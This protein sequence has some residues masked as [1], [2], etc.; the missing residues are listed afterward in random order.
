M[1]RVQVA[2]VFLLCTV[3]GSALIFFS[4]ARVPDPSSLRWV[5]GTIE[6]ADITWKEDRNHTVTEDSRYEL[7][8]RLDGA[9]K[10]EHEYILPQAALSMEAIRGLLHEEVQLDV[11]DSRKIYG[12]KNASGTVILDYATAVPYYKRYEDSWPMRFWGYFFCVPMVII[13]ISWTYKTLRSRLWPR[14]I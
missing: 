2:F 9:G 8:V 3:G 12:I 5:P 6:E 7:T 1:W 14:S 13:A 10:D 4:Y 11:Y